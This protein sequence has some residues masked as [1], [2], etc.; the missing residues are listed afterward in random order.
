MKK[1]GEVV[2]FYRNITHGTILEGKVS[3][4]HG[5]NLEIRIDNEPNVVYFRTLDELIP[6]YTKFLEKLSEIE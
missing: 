6:R 1:L 5:R 2:Y 4:N 3:N